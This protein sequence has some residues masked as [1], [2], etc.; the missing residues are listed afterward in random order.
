MAKSTIVSS[1][2]LLVCIVVPKTVLAAVEPAPGYDVSLEACI[3]K[4][5]QPC[6]LE[7]FHN[8]FHDGPDVSDSCCGILVE[9]GDPCH[10][11]FVDVVLSNDNF[12][13]RTADYLKRSLNA[14]K[15]CKS[16]VNGH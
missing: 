10:S 6:G 14:W 16:I 7:L 5:T 9:M 15:R 8:I 3:K 13:A 1:V 12:Y 2:L 4:M 11:E